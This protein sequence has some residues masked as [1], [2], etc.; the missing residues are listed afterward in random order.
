M[1][2]RRLLPCRGANGAAF[3]S[4][5]GAPAAAPAEA[6]GAAAV[7]A[8][9]GY[10]ALDRATAGEIVLEGEQMTRASDARLTRTRRG[11]I[12]FVF[13]FFNLIPTLSAEENVELAVAPGPRRQGAA[14]EDDSL[15]AAGK[16]CLFQ[17]MELRLT[18]VRSR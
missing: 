7:A 15:R 1:G 13:Q 18:A 17:R 16:S 5:H 14:Q 2:E 9:N 11:R 3:A 12:G 8:G 10:G 4:G 6:A